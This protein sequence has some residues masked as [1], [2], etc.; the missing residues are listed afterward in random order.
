MVPDLAR[1][2]L[3][4]CQQGGQGFVYPVPSR[5]R[6]RGL[7]R[8]P[9]A[10]LDRES[11]GVKWGRDVDGTLY[12]AQLH[13]DRNLVDCDIRRAERRPEVVT[14]VAQ[15][16]GRRLCFS[17]V[18]VGRRAVIVAGGGE[19]ADEVEA[20]VYGQQLVGGSRESGLKELCS[21]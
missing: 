18:S 19:G 12:V 13:R 14:V 5:V 2:D 16:D 21:G 20:A 3:L 11:G 1:A 8:M 4:G 7:D 15:S 9:N 10:A 6:T 17:D